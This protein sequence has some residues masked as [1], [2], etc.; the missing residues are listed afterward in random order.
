LKRRILSKN[1]DAQIYKKRKK[2][3]K[4]KNNQTKDHPE[5]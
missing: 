5:G 4:Q 2:D 1:E 3:M